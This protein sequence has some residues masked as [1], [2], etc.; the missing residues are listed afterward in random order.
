MIG[1]TYL[2]NAGLQTL[3]NEFHDSNYIDKFKDW[4]GTLLQHVEEMKEIQKR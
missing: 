2:E 1:A 4:L 3:L